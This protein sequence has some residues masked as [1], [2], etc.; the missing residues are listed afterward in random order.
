[1]TLFRYRDVN[2]ESVDMDTVCGVPDVELSDRKKP[3]EHCKVIRENRGDSSILKLEI[4]RVRK[5]G[6]D[7]LKT[8]SD[9]RT[10]HCV[11]QRGNNQ[12]TTVYVE[13]MGKE[14]TRLRG[15]SLLW[16]YD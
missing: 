2:R 12:Q 10:Y 14:L 9:F 16:N 5:E 1:M 15:F 6:N 8:I 4:K 3:P 13:L 7:T 11:A